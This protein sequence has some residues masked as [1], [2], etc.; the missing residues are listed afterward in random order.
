MRPSQISMVVVFPAPFGPRRPKHSPVVH[1]EVESIDGDDIFKRLPK[2]AHTKSS[3]LGGGRHVLLGVHGH[4]FGLYLTALSS[5][6][7]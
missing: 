4:P 3:A 6:A 1:L 5:A 2:I 7:R